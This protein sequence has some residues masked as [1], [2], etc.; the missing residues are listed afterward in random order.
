MNQENR[1][2]PLPLDG[3]QLREPLA[4]RGVSNK[5]YPPTL[6]LPHKGGRRFFYKTCQ[7]TPGF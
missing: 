3:L 5:N 7:K 1:T 6:I 4:R 2:I